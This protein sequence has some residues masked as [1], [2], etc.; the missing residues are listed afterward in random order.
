MET[1]RLLPELESVICIF[2]DQVFHNQHQFSFSLFVIFEDWG[3]LNL[4]ART[5]RPQ[6]YNDLSRIYL[7]LGFLFLFKKTV[8]LYCIRFV[9]AH[10]PQGPTP[11]SPEQGL[12][13]LKGAAM[14]VLGTDSGFFTRAVH[15][16]LPSSLS[17]ALPQYLGFLMAIFS[18]FCL[19]PSA[20][21]YF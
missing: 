17:L 5:V 3:W 12:D 2:G 16:S 20:K 18:P 15:T 7:C 13:V 11:D 21:K 1:Q 9:Y 4:T 6:R 8:S 14:W 10:N 19:F